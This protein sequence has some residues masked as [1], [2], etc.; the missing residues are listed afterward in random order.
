M[1]RITNSL[2]VDNSDGNAERAHPYATILRPDEP[3]P[4]HLVTQ[5]HN[6]AFLWRMKDG[7]NL[8][9]FRP[10]GPVFSAGYSSDG[11]FVVTGGRSVRIFDGNEQHVTFARPLH[12][13]EY[14][15]QGL[16]TSVEFSPANGSYR[17]LTTSYDETAKI[18]DWQ[19][20]RKIARMIHELKGHDG[21][22]RF[23]TWSSD[24]SRVLTV[25]NDAH[26]R[27]WS[28]PPDGPPKSETLKFPKPLADN[29]VANADRDFDQLCGILV[30]WPVRGRRWPRRQHR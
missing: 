9:N 7:A 21:P 19:S 23:G 20:D 29:A 5:T 6:A 30:G 2:R 17:F 16:V 11:R 25:G 3:T 27:V 18:W 1:N 12:K 24:G 10:Q 13:V 22:V 15:H 28:F 8:V 26:P 4:L 14:P